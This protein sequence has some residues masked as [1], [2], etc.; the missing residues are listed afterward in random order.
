MLRHV[1]LKQVPQGCRVYETGMVDPRELGKVEWRE[2]F[3]ASEGGQKLMRLTGLLADEVAAVRGA[4]STEQPGEL[5][6]SM[7]ESASG[8]L[9]KIGCQSES[10][11]LPDALGPDRLQPP[12]M[13]G[14]CSALGL[15][16]G[17]VAASGDIEQA[18][19]VLAVLVQPLELGGGGE[20]G[21]T[22]TGDGG[23]DGDEHVVW[24]A[25]GA[26]L[27]RGTQLGCRAGI[28]RNYVSSPA[29]ALA[30]GRSLR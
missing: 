5:G 15:S 20:Q 21:D 12:R 1:L 10:S 30:S 22:D 29:L 2:L 24:W 6:K 26:S 14:W 18:H 11:G 9:G 23:D 13:W 16:L 19:G 25:A 17:L 7:G 4:L 27:A 8:W 3:E 28:A